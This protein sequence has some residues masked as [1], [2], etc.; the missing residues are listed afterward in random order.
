[1]NKKTPRIAFM[2]D[3]TADIYVES[4][5][6]KYGGAALNSSMWGHRLGAISMALSAVGSD[7]VGKGL[8]A[9]MQKQDLPLVGVQKK[10]GSTSAIEIFLKDG[11]RKYGTW[12]PGVLHDFH[13]R[14]KDKTLLKT[15]DAVVITVYPQYVHVLAELAAWKEKQTGKRPVFVINYGDLR[16][17][18][19]SLEVVYKYLKLAD[20][21]VFGLDKDTD[22]LL[23]NEIRDMSD[24]R[25]CLVTLGKYGSLA[26]AN[27]Q[28]FVQ[29]A[30]EV[31]A[32]DTTGAGDSFLAA[33]LLSLLT[34]GDIQQSLQKGT[35]LA[36]RVVTQVGAY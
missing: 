29:S 2:G 23:I 35:A 4:K 31:D 18:E 10:R 12:K 14:P 16:E 30:Q 19:S 27:K 7:V 21:V 22:E 5:T 26:W 1:M 11:E 3:L 33:F 24:N 13:L 9:Y 8:F 36:A 15:L 28:S 6:V 20:I 34:T 25:I 32:V 17:F